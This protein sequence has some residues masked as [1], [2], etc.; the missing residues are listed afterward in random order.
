MMVQI[1]VEG[2]HRGGDLIVR[3]QQSDTK[4]DRSQE[5]HLKFYFSTTFIDCIHE[6]TP[7]TEGWSVVMT[8][9]LVWKKPLV[10]AL[11][12]INLPTFMSS[13]NTVKE[14][15]SPMLSQDED[16]DTE[17]LVIPLTNNYART[18]LCFANLRGTD[19]LM[20]NL[21]QSTNALEI[22][23]ATAIYYQGGTLYDAH[24]MNN[25][26]NEDEDDGDF[27]YPSSPLPQELE[28]D[29][30]MPN[31]SSRRFM[32]EVIVERCY[33]DQ[34]LFLDGAVDDKKSKIRW[35]EDYIFKNI[36]SITD[37]F[38]TVSMPD[39]EEYDPYNYLQE[40]DFE[41]QQWWYR[42][43]L[44]FHPRNTTA[45]ACRKN[46]SGVVASLK[47]N[48]SLPAN[49]AERI[50]QLLQFRKIVNYHS[51]HALVN[52]QKLFSI[53]NS[54]KATEEGIVLWKSFAKFTFELGVVPELVEFVGF[55]GW[56]SC[57]EFFCSI[58]S[59]R[60]TLVSKITFLIE[61]I[62]NFL[63]V[64]SPL[65]T[66]AVSQVFK[67]LCTTIFT[68][69]KTLNQKTFDDKVN[70]IRSISLNFHSVFLL[71]IFI[72]DHRHLLDD[73]QQLID[74]MASTHRPF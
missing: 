54:L 44:I 51:R 50:A 47:E 61:V 70:Y 46:F 14:I 63:K 19:K 71:T 11:H 22:R 66:E 18:P 35:K 2:G 7:I 12:G 73:S 26:R 33:I 36:T 21:L 24:R 1:P 62:H 60:R 45:L 67:L 9:Y 16:C 38:D 15:L 65:P 52:Y 48:I 4:I 41:L 68:S 55:A 10:V 28:D 37:L 32:A 30:F 23:L 31:K 29:L 74:I 43:V 13:L 8:Y 53:C 40:A 59:N 17:M 72:L 20:A 42:P 56:D 39:K 5:N 3:H 69:G 25:D 34:F 6:V 64:D 27:G 57:S 58:L 49:Q